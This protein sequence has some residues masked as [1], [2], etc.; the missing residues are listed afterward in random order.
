[1]IQKMTD[2]AA[3]E[4]LRTQKV[5]SLGCVLENGGPY[6]VPVNYLLSDETIYSHSLPG[7]KVE[8]MRIN[9]NVCVQTDKVEDQGF[10]WESVIAFGKFREITDPREKTEILSALYKRFPKFTPVEAGFDD[11]T[12][13]EKIVVFGIEIDR[14]TGVSECY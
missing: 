3:M 2:E 7:Q 8:A 12:S 1:M 9:P 11:G 6:V 10:E 13:M 5:G 4:L 14:L